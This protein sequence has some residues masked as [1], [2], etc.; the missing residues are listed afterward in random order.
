MNKRKA[1]ESVVREQ[2]ATRIASNSTRAQ[3]E[4]AIAGISAEMLGP[5]PDWDRRL[6]YEDRKDLRAALAK[7]E[8]AGG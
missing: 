8:A 4:A 7:L 5:M 1:R 3:I 2:V 6:L